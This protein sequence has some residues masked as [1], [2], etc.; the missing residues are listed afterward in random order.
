MIAF[1]AVEVGV[2]PGAVGALVLLCGFVGAG[3]VAFGV[4]PESGLGV[5]DVIGWSGCGEGL[6]EVIEGHGAHMWD[7]VVTTIVHSFRARRVDFPGE[8]AFEPGDF[9][10]AGWRATCQGLRVAGAFSFVHS[11]LFVFRLRSP[12]TCVVGC[13]LAPLRGCLSTTIGQ[14]SLASRARLCLAHSFLLL[15]FRFAYL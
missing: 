3:P 6:T 15:E 9:E 14:K 11:G 13:N 8:G 2:D 7:G 12:T 5:G 10:C 4:P 1:F